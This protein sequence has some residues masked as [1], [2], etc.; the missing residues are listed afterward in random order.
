MS[1]FSYADKTIFRCRSWGSDHPGNTWLADKNHA[2]FLI[3]FFSCICVFMATPGYNSAPSGLDPEG[4]CGLDPQ[5]ET[6]QLGPVPF[7]E[8]YNNQVRLLKKDVYQRQ[9][10]MI[11]STNSFLLPG[12]PISPGTL[13]TGFPHSGNRALRRI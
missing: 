11:L 10:Q 5:S 2:I 3:Q 1:L 7:A 4:H 13:Q 9:C 12:N 8:E 6:Q